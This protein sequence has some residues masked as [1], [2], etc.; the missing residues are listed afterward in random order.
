MTN[1]VTTIKP[2]LAAIECPDVLRS[3]PGWLTWRLE[4]HDGEPKPRKV[5]Y[6]TRPAASVTACR[7]GQRIASS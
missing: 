5:P 3:L 4:Y 6:Y 2:H 7:A 1:P